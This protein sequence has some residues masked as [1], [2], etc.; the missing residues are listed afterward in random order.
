[1]S[2]STYGYIYNL[3][4]LKNVYLKKLLKTKEI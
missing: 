1:M 4:L 2:E 3:T